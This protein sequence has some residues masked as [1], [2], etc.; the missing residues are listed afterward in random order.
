MKIVE[1]TTHGNCYR[2]SYNLL[3]ECGDGY[4]LVH[5]YPRNTSAEHG[6]VKMGHAWIEDA[7]GKW[8]LDHNMPDHPVPAKLY[9]AVGNINP[10]EC[11]RFTV[12]QASHQALRHGHY[13]PW[14]KVPRDAHFTEQA[15]ST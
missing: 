7:A 1:S 11:K 6:G 10:H 12:R 4:V 8:V 3:Q 14:G 15:A 2:A 9:Y 5:G 13:G